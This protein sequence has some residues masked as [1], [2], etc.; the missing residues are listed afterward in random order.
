MCPVYELL[1]GMCLS[2]C[3]EEE[4]VPCTPQEKRGNPIHVS[5]LAKWRGTQHHPCLVVSMHARVTEDS[6][7]L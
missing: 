1:I 6:R 4:A 3:T 5:S 7:I 2:V